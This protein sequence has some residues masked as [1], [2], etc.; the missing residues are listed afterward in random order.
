[1]KSQIPAQ[2]SSAAKITFL[3]L[4]LWFICYILYPAWML[5]LSARGRFLVYLGL[6][7][8]FSFNAWLLFRWTKAKVEWTPGFPTWG[9]V[10]RRIKE[11]SLLSLTVLLCAGLHI[12]SMM[13]PIST[14]GD[15]D[16]HSTPGLMIV[17]NIGIYSERFLHLSPQAL[18]LLA[19]LLVIIVLVIFFF[20][21][22]RI[23]RKIA[24]HQK[25]LLILA[26]CVVS[27][28]LGTYFYV[29]RN[30][31]FDPALFK[32]P[33]LERIALIVPYSLFGVH[34]YV[35]RL[36]SLIFSLLTAIFMFK[37]VGLYR[38]RWTATLA[39]VLLIFIPTYFFYSSLNYPEAGGMLFALLASFYFLRHT[40]TLS[41]EDLIL[42]VFF[43]SLGALYKRVLLV[44]WV[45][46]GIHWLLSKMRGKRWLS[47]STYPKF[48]WIGMVP[49]IPQWV[50]VGLFSNVHYSFDLSN[51]TALRTATQ[52]LAILP[53]QISIPLFFLFAGGLIWSLLKRRD[54]LVLYSLILFL[55]YYA[56]WTSYF[57]IGDP[58]YMMSV[59]PSVVIL[60]ASLLG[61]LRKAVPWKKATSLLSVF[62]V[63]FL[64]YKKEPM[65]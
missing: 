16:V 14:G 11:N 18:V 10:V 24:S 46:F 57:Y 56:F 63:G 20:P 29:L 47:W 7:L 42:C 26:I 25:K 38:D 61:G 53:G 49:I 6:I 65:A 51:W 23:E 60:A 32:F 41:Y 4:G 13:L 43:V 34:E 48:V 52:N 54:S 31:P 30:H 40:K 19:T 64:I 35:P 3:F 36:P 1:M 2:I 44:M 15:E 50:M 12:Y 28:L 55:T 5:P 59:L 17:K 8:Y 22:R 33:P 9:L 62:M 27:V 45:V 58:R 39:G 21:V 37:L